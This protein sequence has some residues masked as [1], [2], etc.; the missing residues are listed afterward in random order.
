[1]LPPPV[2]NFAVPPTDVTRMCP[3]PVCRNRASGNCAAGN[4]TPA[5]RRHHVARNILHPDVS[6]AGL[7]SRAAS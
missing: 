5:G 4:V 6:A 1:M 3:P 2:S 7:E